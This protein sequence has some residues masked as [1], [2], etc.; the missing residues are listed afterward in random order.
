MS[1][2]RKQRTKKEPIII[3]VDGDTEVAYF[4]RLNELKIFPKLN[5]K[6]TIGTELDASYIFKENLDIQHKFVILDIDNCRMLDNN[7]REE[8]IRKIINDKEFQNK[9]FYNNYAFETFLLNHIRFFPNKIIKKKEYDK[10]M[11][12]HFN[13]ENWSSRGSTQ[14]SKITE[15]ITLESFEVMLE[16]IPKIYN[17]DCFYNPNSNLHKLFEILKQINAE[18]S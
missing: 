2:K 7:N 4:R 18:L 16:N 9:I 5:F 6:P 11:K 8:K 15:K 3:I 10:Y 1:S 13:V 12:K 14:I 17:E